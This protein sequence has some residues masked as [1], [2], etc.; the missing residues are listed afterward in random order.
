[1]PFELVAD[2]R[3]DEIGSIGIEAF[4]HHEIDLTEVDI[5]KI[6]R[7]LLGIGGPGSQ[8]AHIIGHQ[9]HP[10]LAIQWDGIWMSNG[11][12]GAHFQGGRRNRKPLPK[13]E[14]VAAIRP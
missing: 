8:L 9:A 1:M 10:F 2:R 6:D 3:P 14:E 5:A 11:C 13:S 12:S 4:L 7:D